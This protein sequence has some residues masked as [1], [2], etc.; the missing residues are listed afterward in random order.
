MSRFQ[1]IRRCI[2]YDPVTG[3]LTW[4]VD[5]G[6]RDGKKFKRG[7]EAGCT[8]KD[9]YRLIRI[10]GVLYKSHR[11]AWFLHYGEMPNGQIDHINHIKDDNR[12]LNLR[13]VT[14]KENNSNFPLNK[15]NKTG[16]IGCYLHSSGRY[17][18]RF[19]SN[20]KYVHIGY[21][22]KHEDALEASKKAHEKHGFHLNHGV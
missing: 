16:I 6:G 7:S 17:R 18:V 13:C 9:G 2:A 10:N 22:D 1:D 11:V 4:A 14:N 21:F 3:L 19:C 8:S 20:G 5:I 12:I 15:R